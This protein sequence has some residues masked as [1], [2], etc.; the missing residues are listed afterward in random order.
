MGVTKFFV[1]NLDDRKDRLE[2][3]YYQLFSLGIKRDNI[4]RISA[5]DTRKASFES[6]VNRF[7]DIKHDALDSLKL[8]HRRKGHHELTSG[9]IGCYYSHMRALQEILRVCEDD[10]DTVV[11]VE[12]DIKVLNR[13]KMR[14]ILVS[15]PLE[16]SKRLNDAELYF[17]GHIGISYMLLGLHCYAMRKK[18]ARKLLQLLPPPQMQL[19]WQFH[20]FQ[21]DGL[22]TAKAAHTMYITVLDKDSDIQYDQHC[23]LSW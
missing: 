15:N 10:E 16:L 8:G 20:Q 21:K 12:D 2:N 23:D 9:S 5:V 4:Y 22:L 7:P 14:N 13:D 18:T 6:I 17:I 1:I 11:I 19:D 3:A